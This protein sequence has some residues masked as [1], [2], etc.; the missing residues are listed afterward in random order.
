MQKMKTFAWAG[1]VL[2]MATAPSFAMGWWVPGNG[3]GGG[4]PPQS[5][6]APG[7]V[8]GLGLPA[9]AIAGG[10]ALYMIRRRK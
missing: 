6:S 1:A 4:K 3:D 9:L 10:Y 8:L 5:H 7:P 2:L